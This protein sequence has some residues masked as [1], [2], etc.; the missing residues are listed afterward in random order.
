MN[1]P[2][3]GGYAPPV[4]YQAPQYGGYPAYPQ[5]A[6]GYGLP[7]YPGTGSYPPINAFSNPYAAPG[8]APY[9]A[10]YAGVP[11]AYQPAPAPA[12]SA[13]PP[14]AAKATPPPAPTAVS[15]KKAF[16]VGCSYPGS[17]AQLNGC[18]NDVKC[19]K[20]MLETKFGYSPTNM[21]VQT[22]DQRDPNF[23]PTK[24]NIFRGIEWLLM[25][26]RPGDHL[27]FHFS[28]HGGQ[29]RD[30]G[31]DEADGYDETI[32][33]TDFRSAGVIVDDQLNQ[34]LVR[35]IPHGVTLHCVFDCC[36]SGTAMDLC[37]EYSPDKYGS[38]RWTNSY[39]P[40][41]LSPGGFVAQFSACLDKQTAADTKGLSGTTY[42]GAATFTFIQA[43]EKYGVN[44]SYA[45]VVQ[46]MY[47]SLRGVASHTPASSGQQAVGA[48]GTV[49]ATMAFGLVGL[50]G[51][52]A[53][54]SAMSSKVTNQ[55]PVLCANA[56]FDVNAR[57]HI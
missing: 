11:S 38:Y 2:P 50:L 5:P 6:G 54:N 53:V 1:T 25:D 41:R 42:T 27:F 8:A 29:Q 4:V 15:R 21:L 56:P 30:Y 45:Q 57:I 26:M 7:Q 44:Q 23:I 10:P 9:Q 55:R 12:P 47:E 19:M 17:S 20:Y 31:G 34:V 48:V 51:G 3:P 33:P 14:A 52:M 39:D 22:D 49:A 35:R 18:I 37:A 40:R 32:C 36:H 16:L 24:A 13:P 46:H 43:I 28:G